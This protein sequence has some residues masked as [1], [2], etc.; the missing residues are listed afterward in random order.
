MFISF[1]GG[2]GSG[3]TTQFRLL[4]KRLRAQGVAVVDTREPGGTLIGDEIRQVVHSLKHQQMAMTTEVLLY[5]ASRAQLV[6]ELI[7]PALGAGQLV[8]TDRFADS[9]LAYQGYGRG[10]DLETLRQIIG[11]ATGGLTPDVTVYLDIDPREGLQRRLEAA[12]AGE[13]WNRLDALQLEFH[14]RVYA[15]YQ[16]LIEADPQRWVVIPAVGS[17]EAIHRQICERLALYLPN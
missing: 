16:R 5:V 8:L 11:F 9:T 13:E 17:V 10:L 15:G 1:E 4:V 12:E 3:K 14:Q 2:D 6:A 7:R